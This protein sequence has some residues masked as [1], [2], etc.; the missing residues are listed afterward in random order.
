LENVKGERLAAGW[1]GIGIRRCRCRTKIK[2]FVV[3]DKN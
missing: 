1:D 3:D 2:E